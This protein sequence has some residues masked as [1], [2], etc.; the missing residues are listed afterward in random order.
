M[1]HRRTVADAVQVVQEAFGVV[2]GGLELGAGSEPLSVQVLPSQRAP[3][4][5][6][7]N[8]KQINTHLEESNS[9]KLASTRHPFK[10]MKSPSPDFCPGGFN[11]RCPEGCRSVL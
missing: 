9:G 3:V 1:T 10:P 8:D 11:Y 7:T 5:A 6:A 4:T 2:N